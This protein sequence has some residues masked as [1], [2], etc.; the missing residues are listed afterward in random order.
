M[1]VLTGVTAI[2]GGHYHS[3]ALKTDGTVWAWGY[4]GHGQLGDGTT[5]NRST[6]V[7]VLTGVTAIAGGDHHSLAVKTDGTVWAW[8]FNQYGELGDAPVSNRSP[9]QVKGLTGVTALAAG[10]HHSLALKTDGTIW[11]LGRND[12]YGQLGDGTKTN[13]STPV[14]VKDLAGVTAI[15]ADDDHSLAV[16]TDGTAWAW[17]DNEYGQLGDGTTTNR[18]VPVQVKSLTGVTAIAAGTNHSLAANNCGTTVAVADF[19]FTPKAS[20]VAQGNCAT[21]S[22]NQGTHT[23]TDTRLLGASSNP[24]FDSG[25]KSSGTY[26]HDFTAAGNY[27][28]RS[29]A[30]GDPTTMTGTIKVPLKTSATTGTPSTVITVTW[31]SA[32][33]S[34]YRSDVQYRYK[35]PGGTYGAWTNWKT[36]QT[37]TSGTF[38]ASTLKGTGGYQLRARIEN[39]STL[40]TSL[41]WAPTTITIS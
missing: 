1:Q 6:P 28:Y 31:S 37:T 16:K 3:L 39:A 34:G 5:T 24:L 20:V 4:N 32:S 21:W 27:P 11:A 19:S 2:A 13:N 26:S 9:V 25:I 38:K 23:A 17:G 40:R 33:V 7:Q 36:D 30:A 8:G 22:F 10:D 35:A 12:N 18:S 29:N 14:Q 41:W 15:A